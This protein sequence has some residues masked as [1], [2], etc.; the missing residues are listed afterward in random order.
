MRE[1]LNVSS[2]RSF[3]SGSLVEVGQLTAGYVIHGMR[4]L[5]PL[6]LPLPFATHSLS[7]I[8]HHP[9]RSDPSELL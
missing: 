7:V 9:T 1:I 4:M 2:A 5:I 6:Y 8:R 3:N